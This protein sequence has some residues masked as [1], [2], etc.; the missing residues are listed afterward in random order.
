MNKTKFFLAFLIASIFGGLSVLMVQAP[1]DIGPAVVFLFPGA[2]LAIIVS[3]NVHVF[4]TWVVVVGNFTFY[5]GAL[6]FV[7]E[8]W[9]RYTQRVHAGEKD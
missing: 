2:V 3:G 7:W 6:Y 9:E 1:G 5:L 4:R 8:I